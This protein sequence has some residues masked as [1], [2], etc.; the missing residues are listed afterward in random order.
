MFVG[1]DEDELRAGFDCEFGGGA[2]TALARHL[3]I[4]D[5]QVGRQPR[6]LGERLVA[7]LR[8]ADDFDAVDIV[9][10]GA[11]PIE[12]ESLRSEEHTSELPSLMRISYAVF[13][14]QKKTSTPDQTS[15]KPKSKI[16]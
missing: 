11:Q 9:E 14:L 16:T 13:C 3:H 5:D 2:Q 4:E 8:L 7:V 10:K 6:D 12:S 1:C 15:R